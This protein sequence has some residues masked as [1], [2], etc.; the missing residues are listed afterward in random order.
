[1]EANQSV[2]KWNSY[3]MQHKTNYEANKMLENLLSYLT[4]VVYL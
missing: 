3:K 4:L 2:M 1:M